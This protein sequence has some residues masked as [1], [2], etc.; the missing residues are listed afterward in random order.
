VRSQFWP[1]APE[2]S[3]YLFDED[4]LALWFHLRNKCPGTSLSKF[5]ETLECMS[6]LGGRVRIE[7][8]WFLL[9]LYNKIIFFFQSTTINRLMFYFASREYEF[10]MHKVDA[11]IL[12]V[13]LGKCPG[14][15]NFYLAGHMDG[16]FE[17]CRY[18]KNKSG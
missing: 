5:L 13:D 9:C 4:V 1:G 16:N 3:P 6:R 18:H 8:Y 17:L 12:L 10:F 7:L 2:N 14:C 11:D 15:G